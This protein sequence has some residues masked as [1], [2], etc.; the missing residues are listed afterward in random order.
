MRFVVLLVVLALAAVP[1]FAVD[2]P[3]PGIYKTQYGQ[4][5]EGLF[6][7]SWV[8]PPHHE[9]MIHNTIHAWD[10]AQGVQW[11]VYCPS[12]AVVTMVFD[13]RDGNGN[14]FVQYATDY[15]GGTLWLSKMGPWGEGAAGI[16]F[17]ATIDQ[18][19]VTSTHLY[20]GGVQISVDSDI[21][22]NGHFDLPVEQC[23]DYVLSNG[24]IEGTTDYFP[25]PAGYPPFLDYYNCPAGTVM[26]GAWGIAHDITLT[27]YGDCTVATEESTWGKIKSLY[28]E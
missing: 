28:S 25:L 24:A 18:F 3:T 14:G 12:A 22:F 17:T 1:A 10:N 7:E 16:D 9:G 8:D 4:M 13:T 2:G 19:K 23:F 26:Y 15:T 21:L 27:I 20:Q 6:S 11:Q 5:M